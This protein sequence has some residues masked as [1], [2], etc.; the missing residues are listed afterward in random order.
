MSVAKAS[1]PR[2]RSFRGCRCGLISCRRRGGS[3]AFEEHVL[4]ADLNECLLSVACL[5]DAVRISAVDERAELVDYSVRL[6]VVVG[7]VCERFQVL[8]GEGSWRA[9][10]GEAAELKLLLAPSIGISS[11]SCSVSAM[12]LASP[13]RRIRTRC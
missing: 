10:L 12:R 6:R 2:K 8:A 3:A 13:F 7:P 11:R 9:V 5:D 1:H 4:A